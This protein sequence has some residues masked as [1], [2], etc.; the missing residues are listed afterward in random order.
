MSLTDPC[1]KKYSVGTALCDGH[2][3]PQIT[4]AWICAVFGPAVCEIDSF[5]TFESVDPPLSA[6]KNEGYVNNMFCNS[7]SL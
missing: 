2:H 7:L 5:W 1:F 6:R 3:G 4:L